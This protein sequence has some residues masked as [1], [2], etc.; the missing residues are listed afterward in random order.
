MKPRYFAALACVATLCLVAAIATY[1]T[2]VPWSTGKAGGA[3]LF[4]TLQ[5]DAP[6]IATIDI[7]KGTE[8]ITLKRSGEQWLIQ[9]HDNF[10]ANNEKV[11]SLLVKLT[12]ARLSEPKTRLKKHYPLLELDDPGAKTSNARYLKALDADGKPIVDLIVGKQR[13][14]AF[15]SGKSGTYIRRPN[16]EQTW[17]VSTEIDAGAS[18]DAWVNPRLFEAQKD[19][20]KQLSIAVPGQEPLQIDWDA[21][22]RDFKLANIPEGMKIKYVNSIGDIVDAARVLDFTDVRKA[23]ADAPADKVSTITAEMQNGMK[24]EI[25]LTRDSGQVWVSLSAT[26]DG[27]AKADADA[28][29][30]RTKGWDFRIPSTKADDILKKREDLLEKISS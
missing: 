8:A 22:T 12:E 10:P 28:L 17:L 13:M 5:A 1:A 24:V 25:K 11:R 14:D 9:Q 18:L 16:E 4:P 26:G 27:T 21:G 2:S 15:G 30:A 3:A 23:K 20:V 29:N 6:K 19:K 7:H